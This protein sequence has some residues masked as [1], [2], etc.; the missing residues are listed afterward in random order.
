M[1]TIYIVRDNTHSI[2]AFL[3]TCTFTEMS[4]YLSTKGDNPKDRQRNLLKK[5]RQLSTKR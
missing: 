2:T 3:R 5:E 4:T 1:D